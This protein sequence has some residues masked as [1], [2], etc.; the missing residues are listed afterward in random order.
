[1]NKTYTMERCI[2]RMLD[3]QCK[4]RGSRKL[5][6]EPELE[7]TLFFISIDLKI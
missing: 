6:T 4:Q 2:F 7:S 3:R 1:M 5:H